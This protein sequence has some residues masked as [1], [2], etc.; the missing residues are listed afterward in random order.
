MVIEPQTAVFMIGQVGHDI[1]GANVH[2]V[3]LHVAGLNPH[4]RR[5]HL[6]RI[7][8]QRSAYHTI[9]IWPGH[10]SHR[11]H[12]ATPRPGLLFVYIVYNRLNPV[13]VFP[14]YRNSQ[15]RR[16]RP[17]MPFIWILINMA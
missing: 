12:T 10:H 9:E 3:M 4:H 1:S 8:Q 5:C 13:S 6:Q 16:A 15:S 11:L 17:V 7:H 2:P 14:H